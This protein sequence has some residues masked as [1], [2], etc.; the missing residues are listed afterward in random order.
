M[1]I[2]AGR[3]PVFASSAPSVP[4]LRLGPALPR[5]TL[6]GLIR[7]PEILATLTRPPAQPAGTERELSIWE[8]EG[9]R[10]AGHADVT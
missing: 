3:K 6:L 7:V 4:R 2:T 8:S 9:G 1:R 5:R 10:L